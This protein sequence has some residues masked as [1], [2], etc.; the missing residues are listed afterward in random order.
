MVT[1]PIHLGCICLLTYHFHKNKINI[2]SVPRTYLLPF[3]SLRVSEFVTF[4]VLFIAATRLQVCDLFHELPYYN[5]CCW[6]NCCCFCFVFVFVFCIFTLQATKRAMWHLSDA[7]APLPSSTVEGE[8]PV[9]RGVCASLWNR[10]VHTTQRQA[11]HSS[12]NCT[13]KTLQVCHSI[14]PQASSC[15]SC[16][17]SSTSSSSSSSSLGVFVLSFLF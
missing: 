7:L 1:W 4:N 13:C 8:T 14:R 2:W 16:S 3:G 12:S 10:S 11:E 17:C 15:C 6:K 5:Y 9:W